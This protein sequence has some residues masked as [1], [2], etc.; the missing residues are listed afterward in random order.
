MTFTELE[1]VLLF[2]LIILLAFHFSQR[3]LI[4]AHRAAYY[5]MNKLINDAA[6][7]KVAIYRTT[8]GAIGVKPTHLLEKPHE[9]SQQ[10]GQGQGPDRS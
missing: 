5:W 9:T 4:A 6:D 7:K 8:D 1:A 10:A 3:R 2:A